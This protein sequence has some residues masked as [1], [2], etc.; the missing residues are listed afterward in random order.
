MSVRETH[1]LMVTHLEHALRRVRA[2]AVQAWSVCC[3]LLLTKTGLI[4]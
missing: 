3:Q 4:P 1:S 2:P